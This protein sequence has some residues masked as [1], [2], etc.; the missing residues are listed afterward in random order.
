MSTTKTESFIQQQIVIFYRNNYCLN[1]HYPQ[2]IIFS[3]PNEGKSK[4]ETLRKKSIGMMSGVSDLIIIT[5]KRTIF[6]EVKTEMGV[7]SE[8]QNRFQKLVEALGYKY[9]LVRSLEDFKKQMNL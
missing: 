9:L 2:H 3:V 5:H 8:S 6:V 4:M 1:H 7:Q